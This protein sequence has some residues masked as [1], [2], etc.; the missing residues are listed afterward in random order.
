MHYNY[1]GGPL[2]V[3]ACRIIID[4]MIELVELESDLSYCTDDAPVVPK[5]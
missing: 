5:Y 1:I 3:I 4:H 2:S